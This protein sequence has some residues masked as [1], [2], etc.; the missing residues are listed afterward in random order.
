MMPVRSDRQNRDDGQNINVIERDREMALQLL[1]EI[2]AALRQAQQLIGLHGDY[3]AIR[4]I[5]ECKKVTPD[6]HPV[7]REIALALITHAFSTAREQG[8]NAREH[9]LLSL[10]SRDFIIISRTEY[11]RL[12]AG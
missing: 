7:V 9:E 11:E 10:T 12:N 1:A 8:R 2:T 6:I 3:G 4:K 5:G